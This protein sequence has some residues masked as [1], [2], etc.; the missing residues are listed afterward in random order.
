MG[1][2]DKEK[3]LESGGAKAAGYFLDGIVEVVEHAAHDQKDIR[4]G[5]QGVGRVQAEK[6]LVARSYGVEVEHDR[7]TGKNGR[8]HKRRQDDGT[9]HVAQL[10]RV[11]H[12]IQGRAQAQQRGR[13]GRS[14]SQ[15][16]AEYEGVDHL[17][18][19]H[20]LMEPAQRQSLGRKVQIFPAV[21]RGQQDHDGGQDQ[22]DV[23]SADHHGQET[24]GPGFPLVHFNPRMALVIS[25]IYSVSKVTTTT[26]MMTAIDAPP[27]QSKA[28]RVFWTIS[29]GVVTIRLPPS[30]MGM[31]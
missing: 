19:V 10:A 2:G 11:A 5:D 9:Q 3:S 1:Q 30:R 21:E 31:A 24:I 25:L 15:L 20:Q 22:K 14:Q 28:S 23:Y 7:Q 18:V 8:Q 6:A 4:S 26:N 16:E 13:H 12:H 27:G 29:S 17:A